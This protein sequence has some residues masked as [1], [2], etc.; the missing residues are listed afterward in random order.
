MSNQINNP[1]YQPPFPAWEGKRN[2]AIV[3]MYILVNAIMV[4]YCTN[5]HYVDTV[6]TCAALPQN[7][8]LTLCD[9]D[10]EDDEEMLEDDADVQ[11]VEETTCVLN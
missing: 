3:A 5:A 10:A 8:D 4:A 1:D 7:I 11:I 2:V 6:H 9:L